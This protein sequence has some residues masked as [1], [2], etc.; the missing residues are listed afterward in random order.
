MESEFSQLFN[1]SWN[2][3]RISPLHHGKDCETLIDPA[4]LKLYATRL[5]DYLTGD[6]FAGLETGPSAAEDNSFSKTGPLRECLW[7]PITRSSRDER[8]AIASIKGIL[9][10]LNYEKIS[11]KAALLSEISSTSGPDGQSPK[12][13]SLPLLLTKCSNP[14]RQ[15]FISFLSANFDSYCSALRLP[16]K[17]LCMGLETFIDEFHSVREQSG[18]TAEDA[19]KELH[20]TLAFSSS[21]AP[22]LR[23]LNINISRSSL[24]DFLR[25][26]S[27]SSKSRTLKE[28]LRNPL[29][30]NLTSYIETH[31]AMKLDLDG[32]SQDKILRQHIRLSKISCAPFVLGNEGRMKLV[33]DIDLSDDDELF[34]R[35][36]SILY[37]SEMLLLK[38]IRR[39]VIGEDEAT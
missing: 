3:H 6:V 37:A 15:G 5:R 23:S 29:I 39:A 33:V 30:G 38:V 28:K 31:L 4:S 21:I 13:T 22:A 20:L 32:S 7:Q 14:V 19:I 16:S 34:A 2:L 11:Y 10:I 17:F 36:Q 24:T 12:S 1:T 35:S 25:D 8:A 9:V 18:P 27:S 26:N